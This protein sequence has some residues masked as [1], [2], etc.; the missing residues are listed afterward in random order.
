MARVGA[1]TGAAALC[2][3]GSVATAQVLIQPVVVELS[4]RQRVA[5]V[6]ISLSSKATAPLRLQADAMSWAQDIDGQPLTDYTD[7]LL[8]TP[9][10][11]EIR[12]GER[13]VLR[14]A[15]RGGRPS[16][17]EMAYR[18]R[19]EDISS[20]RALTEVG[21]GVQIRF[22]TNYDLPVLIAPTGATVSQLRW[23][24][25]PVDAVKGAALPG[26]MSTNDSATGVPAACVRVLND[27]NRRVK[28]QR[29][30]VIGSDWRETLQL[31]E[32]ATVLVGAEREW[33][34]PLS[35][36]MTGA[37]T[38]VVVDTVQGAAL[39]AADGGF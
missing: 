19:L 28:V 14:V 16:G 38:G 29:V 11:V 4:G 20:E 5:S 26:R 9:P 13:Q 34:I 12:P 33:R 7:D 23:K 39:T 15:L 8:V 1:I 18:L 22:R 21:P 3:L 36:G 32:A 2:L 35:K 25:C 6:S 27:G 17:D 37:P 10:I 24:A 30:T 31:S